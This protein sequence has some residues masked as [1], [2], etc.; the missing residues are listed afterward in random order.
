MINNTVEQNDVDWYGVVFGYIFVG[1]IL[2]LVPIFMLVMFTDI[3]NSGAGRHILGIWIFSA[4][5]GFFISPIII[6]LKSND[7]KL[8]RAVGE[9]FSG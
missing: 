4:A 5:I 9:V 3:L 8:K 7:H 2:S 1:S 6:M